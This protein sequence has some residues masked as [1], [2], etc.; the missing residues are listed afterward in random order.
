ML[1]L[2]EWDRFRF[3]MQQAGMEFTADDFIEDGALC[4]QRSLAVLH[5]EA[6]H[7]TPRDTK[8]WMKYSRKSR[9]KLARKFG[10][11]EGAKQV[12]LDEEHLAHLN[13]DHPERSYTGEPEIEMETDL[14]LAQPAPDDRDKPSARDATET[15]APTLAELERKYG[16]GRD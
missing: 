7:S 16:S 15:P 13:R 1:E 11:I 3:Q 12:P 2:A 4:Y 14:D 9:R 8:K 10:L 6:L 5:G